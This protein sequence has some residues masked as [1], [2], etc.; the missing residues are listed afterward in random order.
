[1]V[2]DDVL[3]AKN[4]IFALD[5]SDLT[6]VNDVE[7]AGVPDITSTVNEIGAVLKLDVDSS[8]QLNEVVRGAE[9]FVQFDDNGFLATSDSIA[10]EFDWSNTH[11]VA[12]NTDVMLE[13]GVAGTAIGLTVSGSEFVLN[14]ITQDGFG[15]SEID[16]VLVGAGGRLTAV[17]NSGEEKVFSDGNVHDIRDLG[18]PVQDTS[19]AQP[20]LSTPRET[21]VEEGATEHLQY[22]ELGYM[23]P[24]DMVS[25]PD[26][27]IGS[28]Q[29]DSLQAMNNGGVVQGFDGDD[30]LYSG[31]GDDTLYGGTG[32]DTF[33]GLSGR[34][35]YV[36]WLGND[37]LDLHQHDAAVKIHLGNYV[38]SENG[39][40]A[41]LSGIESFIGTTFGD[42]IYVGNHPSGTVYGRSGN[43]RIY[44]DLYNDV[45]HGNSGSDY[46][47]S[48]HGD[49]RLFGGSGNDFLNAGRGQ[50]ILFGGSGDDKVNGKNGDDE[51]HGGSGNDRLWGVNNNDLMNGDDGDDRMNGG[52]GE[53]RMNG[54]AGFD[55]IYGGSGDD[56]ISGG[57]GIDLLRGGIGADTFK[58]E[59]AFGVE[60]ILDFTPGFD[61][62]Q[63]N[64]AGFEGQDSLI[65]KD[66]GGTLRITSADPA[67]QG[68]SVVLVGVALDQLGADDISF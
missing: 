65:F 53:D 29:A 11:S 36:G 48:G 37:T 27:I 40:R 1:M 59:G 39:D 51:L 10:L 31:D 55:R 35:A 16:H 24:A 26:R 68:N 30:L 38:L 3:N 22:S 49:D 4:S 32:D 47:Q 58:M 44:S 67:G 62:I 42:Q 45:L 23:D 66:F 2:W 18:I 28:A 57:A 6:P 54:G 17:L 46:L 7:A 64:S 12:P 20:A 25:G 8:D 33:Y 19:P 41:S 13:L 21:P 60:K 43:D 56:I 61:Q 9:T 50:D 34:D 5:F 63:F 14:C 15:G 52:G